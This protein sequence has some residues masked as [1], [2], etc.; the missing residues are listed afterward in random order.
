MDS[1]RIITA[2]IIILVVL[3]LVIQII[4][5]VIV[6]VVPRI[7]A[8][9]KPNTTTSTTTTKTISRGKNVRTPRLNN[10]S[11]DIITRLWTTFRM[12]TATITA[13][14]PLTLQ[15]RLR[16]PRPLLLHLILPIHIPS[17]R[18]SPI[19][20]C[21]KIR[22]VSSEPLLLTIWPTTADT[23][24]VNLRVSRAKQTTFSGAIVAVEVATIVR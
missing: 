24:K 10:T 14:S 13:P 6:V 12:P 17:R 11:T 22:V 7:R 15:L 18:P 23:T 16:Q 9:K 2:V 21:R 19:L 1:H 5:V 8:A 4:V 20:I 3:F